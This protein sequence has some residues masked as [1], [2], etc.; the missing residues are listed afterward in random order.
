MSF[1]VRPHEDGA[2]G[3]GAFAR[4]GGVKSG[5]VVLSEPPLL[6]YPQASVAHRFCGHCLKYLDDR[7]ETAATCSW[8]RLTRFCGEACRAAAAADPASHSPMACAMVQTARVENANDET[9]SALH[10]LSRLYALLVSARAGDRGALRRY[11]AFLSLSYGNMDVILEITS[12][13]PGWKTCVIGSPRAWQASRGARSGPP[14]SCLKR[15]RSLSR[16]PV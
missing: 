2:R 11:E 9:V 3:H 12:M 15:P 6:V 16:W 13:W 5:Q 4:P 14:S 7:S 1:V 8:C 10:F